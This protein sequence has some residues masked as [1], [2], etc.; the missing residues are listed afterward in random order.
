MPRPCTRMP[1]SMSAQVTPILKHAPSPDGPV[2]PLRDRVLA[3]AERE[4][5]TG[6]E[7][8]DLCIYRFSQPTTFTKAATFG[9]TLG[10]VVQGTKRIRVGGC[11]ISVD[12]TRVLV[13][14]RETEHQSAA[15]N[16]SAERPFLGLSLCFGPERV[17]R[18]LL[19]LAE[20]GGP[21]AK[22]TAPA[23]AMPFEASLAGALERLLQ[24][25]DDP[26]DRKLIA[27]LVIDE[28]LYRLLRSPAA[29]AVRSG[30]SHAADA[31]RI[32][33]SMQF[34]RTHHARDLTVHA[35]ARH[36][37]MSPSHFAHRFSAV[38]RISPMRYLRSVRLDR[39]RTLLLEQ[40]ARAGDV[41]AQVGFESPAH[42]AREFKR[43]FGNP[44]SH[45]LR[46]NGTR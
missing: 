36:V 27:P 26:L 10:V 41:A 29:A 5:H 28:I 16:A 22:E 25:L 1:W 23:F 30:V 13:I 39:A 33:A 43:R 19:A 20:A 11:E 2:A 17:A 3:L 40:G 32:L 24:T 9:V 4:G 21:T 42:F 7:A 35:I 46:A 44:P 31:D 37:A 18:A 14:T 38:A 8:P 15:S 34:I 45:Y 6:I 12:P